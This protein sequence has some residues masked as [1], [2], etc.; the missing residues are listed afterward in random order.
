MLGD[1]VV[2]QANHFKVPELWKQWLRKYKLLSVSQIVAASTVDGPKDLFQSVQTSESLIICLAD[3]ANIKLFQGTCENMA[4][5]LNVGTNSENHEMPPQGLKANFDQASLKSMLCI[6]LLMQFLNLVLHY[7]SPMDC[8]VLS[9]TCLF[10]RCT[11][12]ARKRMQ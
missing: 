6:L 1:E 4:K 2:V 12:C 5:L 8:V 3:R 10:T 9:Q 11:K 7:S